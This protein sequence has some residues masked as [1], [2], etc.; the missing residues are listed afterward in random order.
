M[1]KKTINEMHQRSPL[2]KIEQENFI[3]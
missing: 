2:K 3:F 1:Y